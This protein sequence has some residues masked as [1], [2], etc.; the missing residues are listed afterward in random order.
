MPRHE[1]R[2]SID[3]E[4]V[5]AGEGIFETIRVH[6]GAPFR[7]QAH[8]ARLRGGLEIIGIEAPPSLARAEGGARALLQQSAAADAL[9]RVLVTAGPA[10]GRGSGAVAMVLR[11]LPDIPP[12]IR[13]HIAQSVRRV[14]GPMTAAKTTARIA[15]SIALREA[16]RF[17]AFDALLLNPQGNAVETTARN[18]FVVSSEVVRTPSLSEGALPGITR[19]AVLELSTSL[20][21]EVT[22]GPVPLNM[23]HRA[24]EVFLTGSGVGVL[25]VHE[26]GKTRY[27]PVPGPVARRFAKSYSD[28][29]D[30]DSAW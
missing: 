6:H 2:V 4:T 10:Q 20:D 13:L 17:G 28:V 14:P 25:G 18:V 26:I 29:L 21:L 3:D 7:F 5:L 11:N 22:E 12:E 16:R 19:A 24:D 1:A 9:L 30:R 8:M 15:E 23:L 27:A